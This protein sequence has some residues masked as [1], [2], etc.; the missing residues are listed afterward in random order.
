M[1]NNTN[2]LESK[3]FSEDQ[4]IRNTSFNQLFLFIS[5]ESGPEVRADAI[6]LF[7]LLLK[8]TSELPDNTLE[9]RFETGKSNL[10]RYDLFKVLCLVYFELDFHLSFTAYFQRALDTNL[11]SGQD[12]FFYG[13]SAAKGVIDALISI[14]ESIVDIRKKEMSLAVLKQLLDGRYGRLTQSFSSV[15]LRDAIT[16]KQSEGT[17]LWYPALCSSR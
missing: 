4:A 14:H 17:H 11:Y 1:S 10:V 15:Y 13:E 8:V 16:K 3:L 6:K 2:G 12:K 5:G 7:D 9:N